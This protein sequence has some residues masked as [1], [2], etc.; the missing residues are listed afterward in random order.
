MKVKINFLTCLIFAPFHIEPKNKNTAIKWL[1][2]S[3]QP[4][5]AVL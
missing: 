5:T 3:L 1:E 4:H 2:Y